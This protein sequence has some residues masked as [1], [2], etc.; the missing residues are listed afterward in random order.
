M[1]LAPA[2]EELEVRGEEMRQKCSAGANAPR[3]AE[4]WRQLSPF[5]GVTQP[6]QEK[7]RERG[8][9]RRRAGDLGLF[10]AW[11]R[12]ESCSPRSSSLGLSEST[13]RWHPSRRVPPVPLMDR[14]PE[15]GAGDLIKVPSSG[16]YTPIPSPAWLLRS[17]MAKSHDHR[18][19]RG[20]GWGE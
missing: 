18:H 13:Q 14:S 2:E 8:F 17:F 16:I 6:H 15:R 10:C 12:E 1:N 19:A 9:C 5:F 11:G 7:Q 20:V 4:G 3:H